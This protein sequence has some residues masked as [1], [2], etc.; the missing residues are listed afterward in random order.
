MHT[1]NDIEACIDPNILLRVNFHSKLF[2]YLNIYDRLCL[3]NVVVCY[4]LRRRPIT[5]LKLPTMARLTPFVVRKI[6]AML[7]LLTW[8]N[9]EYRFPVETL[10]VYSDVQA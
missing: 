3:M 6:C 5:C 7:H 8:P 2:V 9:L 4:S 10:A 1:W